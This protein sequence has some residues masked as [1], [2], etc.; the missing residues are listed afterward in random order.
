MIGF[1]VVFFDV[2][3]NCAFPVLQIIADLTFFLFH[4]V[5]HNSASVI[6]NAR[7]CFTAMMALH[8][9]SPVLCYELK[10]TTQNFTAS[11][12]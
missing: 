5:S 4:S 9:L 8:L 10:N 1:S 2:L 12:I 6:C 11:E 3:E 7:T